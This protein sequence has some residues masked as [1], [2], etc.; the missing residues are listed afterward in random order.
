M[1]HKRSMRVLMID[2]KI[3]YKL[4]NAANKHEHHFDR[5]ARVKK[6]KAMLTFVLRPQILNLKLPVSITLIRIA[7]RR[8]DAEDNLPAAFK[9]VRDIIASLFLPDLKPGMADGLP[10]FQWKYAQQS[11]EVKEYAI[12][13]LIEEI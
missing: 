5:A 6:E 10:C 8:L 11:G 1:Q 9:S 13:I 12:R 7:P 3:P 4:F 2:E